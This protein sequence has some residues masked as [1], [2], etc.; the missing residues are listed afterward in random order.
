MIELLNRIGDQYRVASHYS[1]DLIFVW[2]FVLYWMTEKEHTFEKKSVLYYLLTLFAILWF[3]ASAK[4]IMGKSGAEGYYQF[5]ML[6]PII[7]VVLILFVSVMLRLQSVG[8][9]VILLAGLIATVF[10]STSVRPGIADVIRNSRHLG[11]DKDAIAVAKEL[12]ALGVDKVLAAQE[13][14]EEVSQSHSSIY[15][16]S[17]PISVINRYGGPSTAEQMSIINMEALSEEYRND[18]DFTTSPAEPYRDVAERF[19]VEYIVLDDEANDIE[20]M[21]TNGYNLVLEQGKYHVYYMPKLKWTV[22]EYASASGNQAMF[23]SVEDDEGHLIIIDGGWT[24]DKDQVLQKIG[25]HDNHVDLWIITHQDPDHVGAF[26][27]IF[28]DPEIDIDVDQIYAPDVDYE[29]FKVEAQPWDGLADY[30]AYQSITQGWDNITEVKAGEQYEFCGLDIIFFNSYSN[31][32]EGTDAINDGSLMF[33]LSGERDSMLFCADVGVGMSQK[34]IEQWGEQLKADYLQ[35]GHHG[36]GGL[37]EE[38][39]RLVQPKVAFSDAP[40][41]LFHPAEGTKYDSREK[42]ALMESMGATVY[43][44]ATAPNVIRLK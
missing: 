17:E 4:W 24:V 30:E 3:P 38:F 37:N 9:R 19:G 23:Y 15:F 7:V 21:S 42:T 31:K 18:G 29:R 20:W 11:I 33:K 32:A 16:L 26:N 12:E 22:T 34:L 2:I 13:F 36:N 14:E 39:Y 35:M 44:Y 41:W 25:A 40:E 6:V 1:L 28:S 10:V 43:Y 27:A 8:K 5:F